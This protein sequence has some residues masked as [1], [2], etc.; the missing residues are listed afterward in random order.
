[1]KKNSNDE[2]QNLIVL[3][4]GKVFTPKSIG[5]YDVLIGGSKILGLFQNNSIDWT[6]S[7]LP[8]NI[9]DISNLN[10]VPGFVDAHLHC[11]GGGG[12]LGPGILKKKK[13]KTRIFKIYLSSK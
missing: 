1:M 6:H 3:K 11:S 12:E 10:I 13:K 4:G 9:I 5:K 2:Q 7:S 8:L